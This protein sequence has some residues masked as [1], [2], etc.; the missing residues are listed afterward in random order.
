M[1]ETEKELL[2]LF[3]SIDRDH[4]GKLE[5][6]ELQSAFRSAGVTVPSSKLDQ[7]FDDVDSNNDGVISYEE[8][9]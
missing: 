4:D 5:K 9:R 6:K 3:N 1:E 2:D 7:L 8:W